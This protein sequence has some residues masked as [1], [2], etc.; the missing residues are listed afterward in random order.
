MADC[1]TIL[2]GIPRDCS[3]SL[4]GIRKVWL[5]PFESVTEVTV[6][7]NDNAVTAVTA[8]AEAKWTAFNLRKN[9]SSLTATQTVSDTQ[10]Y[11]SNVLSLV[12]P[13]MDSQKRLSAAALAVG[14]VAGIV[15][16][17]NGQFWYVGKDNYLS[18]SAGTGATGAASGD[19][20][21]YTVELTAEEVSYPRYITEA[22]AKTILGDAFGE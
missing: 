12:F 10:N 4:G 21:A 9:Q 20:N 14:Q 8:A 5:I 11:F 17:A 3:S 19:A 2:V 6:D 18:A 16:D 15:L 22:N 1:K 13:R 7:E